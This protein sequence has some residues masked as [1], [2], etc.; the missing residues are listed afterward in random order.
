LSNVEA[1][2][3]KINELF[4]Q[5]KGLNVSAVNAKIPVIG[6]TTPSET[7][8]GQNGSNSQAAISFTQNNYSPKALSRLDIYRQTKNQISVM[9]GLVRPV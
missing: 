4:T 6:Q 3:K 7:I 1:G 5:R 2:S 8:A 9:K